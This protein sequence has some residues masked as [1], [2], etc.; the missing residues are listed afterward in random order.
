MRNWNGRETH[1]VLHTCAADLGK[2]LSE[3]RP[4]LADYN[5]YVARGEPPKRIP[6]V[7][8]IANSSIQ[9]TEGNANFA[10]ISL[11]EAKRRLVVL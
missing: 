2:W 6:R 1:F 5:K 3:E 10:K 9:R 11:G 8:L 7:W 4:I